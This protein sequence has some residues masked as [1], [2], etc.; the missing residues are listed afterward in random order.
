M[1]FRN[2]LGQL[3]HSGALNL[4]LHN[5]GHPDNDLGGQSLLN[6]VCKLTEDCIC[7]M[8]NNCRGG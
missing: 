3:I 7:L 2:T 6:P 8:R 1:A 4:G 5:G